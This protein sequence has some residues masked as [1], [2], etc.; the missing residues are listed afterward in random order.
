MIRA[1]VLVFSVSIIGAAIYFGQGMVLPACSNGEKVLFEVPEGDNLSQA[2]HRLKK[3]GIIKDILG[4]KI[5]AKITGNSVI[6]LGEYE[7]SCAQTPLA[8][9]QILNG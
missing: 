7:L 6:R 3:Q 5:L 8:I 4:F 1:L 2:S 9:L